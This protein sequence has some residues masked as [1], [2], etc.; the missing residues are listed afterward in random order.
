[1]KKNLIELDFSLSNVASYHHKEI[2][3]NDELLKH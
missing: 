1:M 2:L 3:E